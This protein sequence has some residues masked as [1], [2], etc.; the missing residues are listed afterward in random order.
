MGI[1]ALVEAPDGTILAEISERLP[2]DGTSNIAEYS[3]II[4]GMERAKELGV[5]ELIIKGDSNLVIQQLRGNFRVTA[6]HL[7]PLLKRVVEVAQGFLHLEASWI[8]REQN[9]RA[10]ALSVKALAPPPMPASA[11]KRESLGS[12][13][14]AREHSILCPRCKKPCTLSIQVFKDGSEHVRQECVEHGFIGYA[15]NVEPFLSLAR[16]AS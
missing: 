6:P 14:T 8:P 13:P 10:D 5:T 9:K 11:P 1:G 15:P 12:S 4:R 2:K 16:K 7:R 3:A